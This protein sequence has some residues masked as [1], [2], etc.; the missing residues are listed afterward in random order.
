[1]RLH[2]GLRLLVIPV[3]LLFLGFAASGCRKAR[4]HHR[5]GGS[6]DTSVPA[7]GGPPA[8]TPP[9]GGGGGTSG[10][11]I[12]ADDFTGPGAGSTIS[13][14]WVTNV[15]AEIFVDEDLMQ[16]SWEADRLHPQ[17]LV[18]E[19]PP[20][21]GDFE[22]RARVY[23]EGAANNCH[24]LIGLAA[25]DAPT[26]PTIAGGLGGTVSAYV[27]WHGGGVPNHYYFTSIWL[28]DGANVEFT[29]WEHDDFGSGPTA[30]ATV[31]SEG[32]WYRII[33]TKSGS[34]V[35][36]STLLDDGTPVGTISCPAPAGLPPLKY[37]W[38]GKNDA[39]DWPWMTGFLDD[40][41]IETLP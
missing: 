41:V 39:G 24:L 12:F 2:S 33:L 23:V 22:M 9:P 5:G 29:P 16:V 8:T 20:V 25:N 18:H 14:G 13:R 31:I 35:T 15:P 3:L 38:I 30:G 7:G 6:G 40:L 34:T 27:C 4:S 32:T 17:M 26:L 11:I 28:E 1:M 19:I 37:V 10:G 21:T 36:L